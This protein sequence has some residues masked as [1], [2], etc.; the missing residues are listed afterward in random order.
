MYTLELR[1][2]YIVDGEV[3]IE[4]PPLEEYNLRLII[5]G[6]YTRNKNSVG[7]CWMRVH[8]KRNGQPDLC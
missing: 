7:H 1:E 5:A 6:L 4:N 3:V 8:C 2:V